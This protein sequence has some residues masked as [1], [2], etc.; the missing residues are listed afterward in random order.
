MIVQYPP[1]PP[2]IYLCSSMQRKHREPR[3]VHVHVIFRNTQ[4]IDYLDLKKQRLVNVYLKT[5]ILSPMLCVVGK[6]SARGKG[7]SGGAQQGG[8]AQADGQAERHQPCKATL[9][10]HRFQLLEKLVEKRWIYRRSKPSPGGG[11]PMYSRVVQGTMKEISTLP[12]LVCCY[13]C[14]KQA[15]S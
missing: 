15:N 12:R 10:L 13:W 9:C 1:S 5:S 14:H 8:A 7:K 4:R 6:K 2:K 3:Y 11:A